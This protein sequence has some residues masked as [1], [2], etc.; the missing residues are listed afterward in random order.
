MISK[1]NESQIKTE[2]L[3]YPCAK[4]GTYNKPYMHNKK[5]FAL[6]VCSKCGIQ[7]K[8]SVAVSKNFRIFCSKVGSKPNR[9]SSYYTSSEM[10]IKRFL[11]NLGFIEGLN[12]FH[13]QRIPVIMNGKKRYF[14]PDFTLPDFKLIL[15]AS[16]SIWHK[17]WARNGADERF[18]DCMANLGW[19][20]IHLDEKDL[21]QLNKRRDPSKYPKT[22]TVK[23]L[24]ELFDCS[25]KYIRKK[26][27]KKEKNK[28][29]SEEKC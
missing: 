20:V 14:W 8:T 25:E 27:L 4:C 24:Y 7:Y 5:G 23:K 22:A 11:D 1:K 3:T 18:T 28:N 16:P 17:M 19:T 6:M 10:K 15:G 9:S 12:Y 13:N 29:I 21:K 2:E 26:I